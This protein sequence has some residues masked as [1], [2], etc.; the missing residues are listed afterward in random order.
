[1]P[2]KLVSIRIRGIKFC[3]N[4]VCPINMWKP[5]YELSRFIN[6]WHSRVRLPNG[7]IW[8]ANKWCWHW[9]QLFT[10][11]ALA[12][13]QLKLILEQSSKTKQENPEKEKG[14]E[15]VWNNLK[16][17]L[18]SMGIRDFKSTPASIK[19]ECMT[20][21]P[22]TI[23]SGPSQAKQG[24]KDFPILWRKISLIEFSKR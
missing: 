5:L 9:P 18:I 24:L 13:T 2:S 14:V 21:R 1:M 4:I 6:N 17:L 7:Q 3:F 15:K 22:V 12:M 19:N 11:P 10:L 20:E 23:S 8:A 16:R